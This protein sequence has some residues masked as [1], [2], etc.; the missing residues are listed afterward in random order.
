MVHCANYLWEVMG[1]T[2]YS[3]MTKSYMGKKPS[4]TFRGYF[5]YL[6]SQYHGYVGPR[7]EVEALEVL[8]GR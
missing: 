2:T 3:V 4:L 8:Q 5:H 1:W 7:Q 6:W